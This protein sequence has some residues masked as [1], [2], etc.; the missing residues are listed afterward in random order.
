MCDGILE[1]FSLFLLRSTEC[2]AS[3][4]PSTTSTKHLSFRFS[5]ASFVRE[6]S[7][8]SLALDSRREVATT[9]MVNRKFQR[10]SLLSSG[11]GERKEKSKM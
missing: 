8:E 3:G 11:E 1:H 9:N 6:T 5:L 2:L 10:H 7:I 4:L